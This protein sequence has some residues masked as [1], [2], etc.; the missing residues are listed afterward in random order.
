MAT[1]KTAKTTE[2]TTETEAAALAAAE[3]AVAA[4]EAKTASFNYVSMSMTDKVLKVVDSVGDASDSA[5][6]VAIPSTM[7]FPEAKRLV[8]NIAL[9]LYKAYRG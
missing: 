1:K 3:T 4:A 2:A 7:Q 6:V 5:V 9:K 8:A